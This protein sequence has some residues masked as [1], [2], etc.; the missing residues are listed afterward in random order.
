MNEELP[1]SKKALKYLFEVKCS[2]KVIS[3]CKAVCDLALKFAKKCNEN[4]VSVDVNLVEIGALLHDIGRSKT[5]D[6]THAVAGVEIARKLNLPESVISI[7]ENHIGG[8]ITADEAKL[9][10]LP[11]KDYFPVT[12]EEKIVSYADKLIEG[13]DTVPIEK[14]IEQFSI[15]LG[16]NHNAINRIRKLHE[17]LHP[18]I[19][20]LDGDDYNS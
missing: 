10:G 18:L 8:G 9:L 20:D 6:I 14:T 19:G 3:H 16:S 15:R 5:H 1:S 7:I 11:E 12:I 17:E 4:G 13:A 2:D